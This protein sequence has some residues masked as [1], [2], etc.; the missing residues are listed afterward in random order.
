VTSCD[1]NASI[2]S[3]G[4]RTQWNPNSNL[5][6]GVDVVWNRLNTANAGVYNSGTTAYG[7]RPAGLY[8]VS[9]YDV[10]TAAIRAQY[11]FLP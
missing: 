9:N 5:D 2:W 3:I 7:G 10:L 11:N 6:L 8:N 4:S 1:P